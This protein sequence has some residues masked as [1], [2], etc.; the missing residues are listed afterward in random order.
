MNA[1]DRQQILQELLLDLARIDTNI[2]KE[3]LEQYIFKLQDIYK[4]DFRH[5][6]SGMF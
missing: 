2:T 4:D 6:Y 1:R 3:N 5:L